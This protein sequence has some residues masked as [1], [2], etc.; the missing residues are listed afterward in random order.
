[1]TTTILVEQNSGIT[2]GI[3]GGTYGFKKLDCTVKH[4]RRN[5]GPKSDVAVSHESC[6]PMYIYIVVIVDKAIEQILTDN[7]I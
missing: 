2:K 3:D 5:T 6:N 4:V 1:M 7:G